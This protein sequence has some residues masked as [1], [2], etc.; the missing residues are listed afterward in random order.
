MPDD[1]WVLRP[2][3]LTDGFNP[4]EDVWY[5]PRVA[6]TFKERAGFHGCQMPEQLLGRI[7]RA[8]SQPG[9][10]VLDPFSGSATTVAVAKKLDRQF[11]AFEL[12]NDYVSLGT[13]RLARSAPGDRLDGAP[14]PKVSAP[15]TDRGKRR[16]GGKAGSVEAAAPAVGGGPRY[17]FQPG[18]FDLP[19]LEQ[20]SQSLLDAFGLSSEGFSVDR[21]VADP[22]LN[23][24]FQQRCDAA[25]VPGVAAERNRQLF[26]LRKAGK[27]DP[28]QFD[29]AKRTRIDWQ[30]CRRFLFACEIA[31]RVRSDYN[32]LS[33]D[34]ILCDPDEAAEFE[35]IAASLAEGFSSLEYRWGA[36]TLRKKLHSA[37]DNADRGAVAPLDPHAA[38]GMLGEAARTAGD[39]SAVPD[40]AAVY[41]IWTGEQ[42][43]CL[44][45]GETANLRDRV[46]NQTAATGTGSPLKPYAASLI[47][48]WWPVE[49]V[50]DF[51]LARQLGI[52]RELQPRLNI[53]P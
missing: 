34:D 48:S 37:M 12:S 2:Q 22:R 16:R 21:V 49:S 3:D 7:I 5:F 13:E 28:E 33:L 25:S 26:R 31:W 30:H 41:A 18:L 9:E 40:S 47:W 39:F 15:P 32:D 46:R 27:I 24:R 50:D 38:P 29:T 43:E 6:G 10:V 1:T 52:V 44:Y 51:P 53:F 17:G 35:R 4:D 11:L 42:E 20:D 8:C 36:L 14:E 19:A 45:V 23:R